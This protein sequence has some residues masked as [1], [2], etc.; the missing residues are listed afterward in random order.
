[1]KGYWHNDA[2]TK[3]SFTADGYFRSGDVARMDEDGFVF[4][5]DR[6]KDMLL[7]GGFNVY[8]RVIEEAIYEHPSVEEVCVI[9][10]DDPYRGQSP[11]AFIKLKSGVSTLDFD[12][13]KVF[14]ESRVGK[15]EMPQS[16]EIRE[17]LP[18]TAVGKLSK[19]ELIDQE[20]AR[21]SLA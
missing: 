6:T 10:V 13:L 19:K 8:P 12:E 21:N 7:C 17:H 9:G 18:K 4:I 1:M 11:K 5:V 3:A 16:I 20:Q 2:A 15:H 14:L